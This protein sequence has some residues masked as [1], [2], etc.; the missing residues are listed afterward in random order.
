V[1]RNVG[2]SELYELCSKPSQLPYDYNT[3]KSVIAS[4]GALCAYSGK[5][6]GRSPLDKRIVM[7]DETEREIWWGDINIP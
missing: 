4:S 3:K 7:D 6:T 2:T 5:R 1:L